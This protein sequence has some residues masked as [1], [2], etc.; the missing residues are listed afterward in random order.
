MH[1]RHFQRGDNSQAIAH[2]EYPPSL[3][4]YTY[5]QRNKESFYLQDCIDEGRQYYLQRKT[6]LKTDMKLNF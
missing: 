1:F 4:R 6:I 3:F 2:N 5:H